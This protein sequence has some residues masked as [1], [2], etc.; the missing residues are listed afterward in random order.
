[1]HFDQDWLVNRLLILVPLWLS[2]SVHEWA[3]AWAAWKLGDDT[4]ALSGRLTLN[5]LAHIDPIGTLVLPLLGIPFGWAKPVPVNPMRF[6]RKVR[7]KTGMMIT[8]L[9]GP[10]SNLVL[11]A[12]SIVI[13]VLVIRFQTHLSHATFQGLTKLFYLLIFMNSALA[14][15]NMLPIPPLDGSRVA[16]ALMPDALQPA[17][18]NLCQAGPILLAA[19]ILLPRSQGISL[20]DGPMKVVQH[21]IVWLLTVVGC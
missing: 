5:P 21:F 1:M 8:A 10:I 17:W 2:L 20:F 16:D 14:M 13:F 7:M 6:T 3:H 12:G 11:A 18:A 19:V 4:A 9:A 15:F